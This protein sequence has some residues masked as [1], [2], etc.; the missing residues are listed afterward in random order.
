[1]DLP[2]AEPRALLNYWMEWEKGDTTPGD[3]LKNLKKS[4]MKEVLTE[5]A[6]G[7]GNEEGAS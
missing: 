7:P 1:M 2:A 6:E 4:G 3:V 5:L